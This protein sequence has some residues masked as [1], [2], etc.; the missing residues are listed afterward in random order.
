MQ[1]LACAMVGTA[2]ILAAN[3]ATALG[4]GGQE[5]GAAPLEFPA[6][7]ILSAIRAQSVHRGAVDWSKV[8]PEVRE[9]L[10]KATTDADRA[11][12]LVYLFSKMHDV[13]SSLLCGGR[14]YSH[15]EALAEDTRRRLLPML[16]R[17]RA[18]SGKPVSRMLDDATAYILVPTMAAN[19][20]AQV[21]K[22]GEEL[23][24]KVGELTDRKPGWW[25]VD[26]RLNGGGNLYPMLLGLYP[27]L[28]DGVAGGTVDRDGRNVHDWLL[29]ADGLYWRDTNGERHFAALERPGR[30]TEADKPVAIL[31]GPL[32]R[33]SGQA[34]ALAF[35]GR[36][37]TRFIGEPTA[38][39]YTTV[40]NPFAFSPTV[41]L[42]LA[43]G[44]M[45]DR[46]G[47]ACKELVEPEVIVD[48]GDAFDAPAEDRKVAAA[49]SWL[50]R[51]AGGLY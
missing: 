49:I 24:A 44:Y 31:L 33:S 28:G 45:A 1:T 48:G 21:R 27:L 7:A 8:E 12:A 42:N 46:T 26:L 18:Q 41:S 20:P 51:V 2:C 23:R 34:T 32:T 11:A 3:Q 16:E 5:F 6:D 22:L 39:G 47:T 37:R 36:P 17:E 50:T 35:K 10:R 4:V 9:R 13:H 25:V 40:T 15:F 30:P 38:K 14:S 43:V 29:K 19:N